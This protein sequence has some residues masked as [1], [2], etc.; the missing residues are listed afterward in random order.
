[1]FLAYPL[2]NH[3]DKCSR[4][5]GARVKGLGVRNQ[6]LPKHKDVGGGGVAPEGNIASCYQRENGCRKERKGKRREG[7]ERKGK[8]RKTKKSKGKE[9]QDRCSL[10]LDISKENYRA[11]K[12]KTPLK[13]MYADILAPR[14]ISTEGCPTGCHSP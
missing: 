10:H 2:T 4:R 13:L 9:R 6:T 7:K 3:C 11:G 14:S 8:E 12:K 5:L 1:M